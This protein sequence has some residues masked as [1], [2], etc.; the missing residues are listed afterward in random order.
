MA[1]PS[2]NA[3]AASD[4]LEAHAGGEV[5]DQRGQR[6]LGVDRAEAGGVPGDAAMGVGGAVDRVHDDEDLPFGVG[7]ARLL[8]E[9]AEAGAVE[10]RQRDLVGGEVA[11][12]LAGLGRAGQAPVLE[13]VEHAA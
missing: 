5:D 9:H 11:E 12:V 3:P 8:A 7:E 1:R 2:W 10:D 6:P 13:A 4:G